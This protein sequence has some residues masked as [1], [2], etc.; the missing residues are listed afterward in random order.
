VALPAKAVAQGLAQRLGASPDTVAVGTAPAGAA[1]LGQVASLPVSELVEQM[2]R[3]SDNVLAEVLA[4]ELSVAHGGEG[5]FAGG[6]RAVLDTLAKAGFDVGGV[7]ISD[8]SGLST[9]DLVPARLLG[10]LL[11]AAAGPGRG[12]EQVAQLRVLAAGLPV[13]GGDGTLDQR[14]GAGASAAG[15]GYV[16]AKTGT[17]NDVTSLAGLVPTA[18]GRLLVFA[19]MS[20]GALPAEVRPRLDAMATVLH[21]CGCR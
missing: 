8:G 10:Q 19:L 7:T 20:N 17:L 6:T 21:S 15:R 9:Q 14:F 3:N 18:D 1:T 12:P 4:R 16:R 2:L 5:S 13:A 11:A